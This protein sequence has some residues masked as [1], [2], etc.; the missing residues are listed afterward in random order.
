MDLREDPGR[1]SAA[2]IEPPEPA[3]LPSKVLSSL[4]SVSVLLLVESL[5][6][7]E[8]LREGLSEQPDQTTKKVVAAGR[9]LGLF[10]DEVG[11]IRWN[12]QYRRLGIVGWN[13]LIAIIGHQVSYLSIASKP[14]QDARSPLSQL[15]AD[16]AGY[17][18]FL[19]GV[20]A[21]HRRHAAWLAHCAQ[22]AA[23]RSLVD[24]GGGLGTFSRAW[25][26]S[27]P[28]R[29]AELL[30]LPGVYHDT[31]LAR[32]EVT[33]VRIGEIDL[34]AS[35]ALPAGGHVYL[36]ANVLHLFCDWQRIVADAMHQLPSG[37]VLAV[38]EADSESS[39]GR[40]FDLQ[41]HLRS[42]YQGGLF[43]EEELATALGGQDRHLQRI[44]VPDDPGDPFQRTYRLWLSRQA[45]V[46]DTDA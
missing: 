6:L 29:F 15:Y 20:D 25:T 34:S 41:V 12:E 9:A 16:G 13:Q 3:L 30:D 28:D 19:R 24:I 39:S 27:R 2:L 44:T 32:G 23:Y 8:R 37:A 7:Y 42:G 17:R 1:P 46:A 21:S 31:D 40:L 18:A 4:R 38:L 45:S 22:L 14:P 36:F 5:G 10:D 11:T 33:G 35:F 43:S 26:D